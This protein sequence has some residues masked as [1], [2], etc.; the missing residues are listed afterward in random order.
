M[1]V[2]LVFLFCASWMTG[3]NLY[4]PDQKS[5]VD[6]DKFHEKSFSWDTAS[7]VTTIAARAANAPAYNFT[8]AQLDSIVSATN[9]KLSNS[10][11]TKSLW[12][13]VD[14]SCDELEIA[15]WN[16]FNTITVDGRILLNDSTVKSHCSYTGDEK[17]TIASRSSAAGVNPPSEAIDRKYPYKM[18]GR[19]WNTFDVGVYKSTGAETQFEKR[20]T[21]WGVTAWYD[22]DASRIG[23]RIYLF[24]CTGAGTKRACILRRSTSDWYAN[25]DYV[26]KREF[27]V[28]GSVSGTLNGIYPEIGWVPVANK[29]SPMIRDPAEIQSAIDRAAAATS[30]RILIRGIANELSEAYS[31]FYTSLGL[32]TLTPDLGFVALNVSDG[33]MALH[34]ADHAGM[35]FRAISSSGLGATAS[36]NSYR[37]LDYVAW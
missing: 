13:P 1:R 14:Y 32:N 15:L 8:I 25:D 10:S 7:H 29:I 17:I 22:T 2:S 34:S 4:D 12:K 20:R 18:I 11:Y 37:T 35:K 36:Y 33:V 31:H 5:V 21:S 9:K 26:S 3:C 23:V 6:T 27:A 19:S 16:E 30:D 24:D 28:G